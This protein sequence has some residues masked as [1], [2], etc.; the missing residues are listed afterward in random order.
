M[1]AGKGKANRAQ[2]V[3]FKKQ[4]G[5]PFSRREV[6]KWDSEALGIFNVVSNL[7]S[8]RLNQ[9]LANHPSYLDCVRSSF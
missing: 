1:G 3:A 2:V 5:A 9:A 4:N 6:A 7:K 8:G